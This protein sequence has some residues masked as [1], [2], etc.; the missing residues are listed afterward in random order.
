MFT[1][2][3]IGILI[4]IFVVVEKRQMRDVEDATLNMLHAR[5][6]LRLIAYVLF[7]VLIMLGIIA[8]RLR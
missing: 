7:G 4:V 5:Q 6:D 3:A 2:I 1:L 8:D